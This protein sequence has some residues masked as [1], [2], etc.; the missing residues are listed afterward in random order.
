MGRDR[1]GVHAGSTTAEVLARAEELRVPAARVND[2]RT[3]I[4]EEQVVARDFYATDPA[5]GVRSPRPHYLRNG[6]RPAPGRSRP[7]RWAPMTRQSPGPRTPP[8]AG[9]PRGE[10]CRSTGVKVL[11]LTAWWAGPAVA[12]VLAAMGAQAV[13]VESLAHLDP[14]RLASA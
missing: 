7:P 5:T 6:R 13:H 4:D 1:A 8:A 3:V 14:M 2:G 11:D 9:E 10:S 12:Q